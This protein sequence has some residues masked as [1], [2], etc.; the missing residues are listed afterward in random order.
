MRTIRTTGAA[1]LG[2]AALALTAPAATAADGAV[3]TPSTIAAGGKVTL[4]APGCAVDATASSGIFDTATVPAGGSAV[5]TVDWDA[6]P[7]AA[8]AVAFDCSGTKSTAQLTVAGGSSAPTT[9]STAVAP[10]T[11]SPASAS[12]LA[13]RGGLGGSV[14]G[15]DAGELAAGTALVVAAATGV[16]F[17]VRRR[18]EGRQH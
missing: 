11:R 13:V 10:A 2:C 6:K 14:G 18:N 9:S 12:P 7:G 15:M 16:V 3:V 4:S 17:A 8:Y 1:L 5:V